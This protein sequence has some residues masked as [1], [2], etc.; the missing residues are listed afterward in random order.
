MWQGPSLSPRCKIGF[1]PRDPVSSQAGLFFGSL[2][3]WVQEPLLGA[4]AA[5]PHSPSVSTAAEEVGV[6]E[7]RTQI[8]T[9]IFP[10][11]SNSS[12]FPC[13]AL[14]SYHVLREA[15]KYCVPS[16]FLRKEVLRG[17]E[18]R[19]VQPGPTLSYSSR[20]LTAA[21]PFLTPA[22]PASPTA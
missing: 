21:F 13:L 3:T 19:P 4:P 5:S 12:T 10:S 1:F 22:D 17:E 6:K 7:G 14:F 2:R 15:E 8:H 11:S 18:S 20:L 9:L 16:H